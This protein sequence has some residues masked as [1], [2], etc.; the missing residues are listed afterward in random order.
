MNDK[1]QISAFCQQ[2]KT[3]GIQANIEQII[4]EAEEK[5]CG[6]W[7]FTRQLLQAE[8]HHRHENEVNRRIKVAMLPQKS[9]LNTYDHTFANGLSKARINQLR[10]LNWIDQLYNLMLMGPSGTG[11][12]FLAAGLC[13]DAVRKG[14]KA[15]FRTLDEI[16]ATL[17]M[18]E[19]T[20][21]AT[22]DYKRLLKAD[23]IV[24]DDVMMFPIEKNQAID[25]FHFIN[26]LYENTAFII[27]TNKMPA[28]WAKMLDDEVLATAILDRLLYQ[29]EIIK[30]NGKSYRMENRK[31]LFNDYT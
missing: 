4:S 15:Y 5:E 10:E 1:Q 25:L 16:F 8:A 3:A 6:F 22:A 21:K 20:R 19:V 29:C 7:E 30:L 31:S 26:H 23:L 13:A 24:I 11:K 28:D 27:T 9:D 12:T 14:Y 17:R 18:K 2:F